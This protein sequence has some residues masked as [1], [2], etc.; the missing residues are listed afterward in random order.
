MEVELGIRQPVTRGRAGGALGAVSAALLY[1]AFRWAHH[2]GPLADLIVAAWGLVTIG[3]L[4]VSVWS[5][6]TSRAS[7]RFAKIGLALTVV[8]LLALVFAGILSAA[9]ISMAGACGGG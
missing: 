8:S 9:G 3:A 6:R 4:T 2:W 7:R 5:L 1:S